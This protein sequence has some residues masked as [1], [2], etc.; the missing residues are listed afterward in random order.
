[1][2]SANITSSVLTTDFFGFD[3]SDDHYGLQG[4]GAVSIMG[5][6]VHGLVGS[7]M[8]AQSPRWIAVRN[9]SDPQIK[10]TGT[11]KTASS[12]GGPD[13]QGFRPLEFGV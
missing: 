9:V 4:L 6:A 10:G 11:L 7:K 8:G 13:L 5:D 1:V 2:P 12:G 3:T